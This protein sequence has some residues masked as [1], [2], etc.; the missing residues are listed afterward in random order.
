MSYLLHDLEF[1]AFR[2]AAA[3]TED[4]DFGGGDWILRLNHDNALIAFIEH[5]E[6]LLSKFHSH[7]LFLC[8]GDVRNFRHDLW[9]DYKANRKDRRRP[10]GY[11]K[12]LARLSEYSKERGWQ[13]GG[14]KNVEGDDVLGILH[15]PGCVIV[16]GDKDMLTLPGQH[17]RNDELI[18]VSE[19]DANTAFYKQTL[20]GDTAD[21]YPGCPG[22]GDK[23][24]LF[25]SKE[26]LTAT[27]EK[28]LWA[29]V[30]HQFQKA[31]F[32]ELHAITQARCARILRV[33]EFDLKA[34]TPHLWEP[35]VI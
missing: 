1:F 12:F 21:N 4:F 28:E 6:E 14:F 34:G 31:G 22:I 25:R 8:R 24:K 29:L 33:G 26:W 18:T 20:V 2:I 15:E 23:N 35:P 32:D 13:T 9:P 7:D 11:G 16:S 30:L 3:N 27:T 5:I 10:P 17:W 19:M